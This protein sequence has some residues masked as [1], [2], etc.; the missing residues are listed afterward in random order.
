VRDT[1]IDGKA[2]HE[3]ETAIEDCARDQRDGQES[4]MTAGPSGPESLDSGA[5]RK[6]IDDHGKVGS[7]VEACAGLEA[8]PARWLGVG[9]PDWSDE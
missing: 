1:G 3:I 7:R 4:P 8:L 9:D 2:A 6:R 5:F